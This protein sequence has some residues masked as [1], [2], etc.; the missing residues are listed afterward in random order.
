MQK[1]TISFE[2]NSKINTGNDKRFD[3]KMFRLS[4][5]N[6]STAIILFTLQKIL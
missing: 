3:A 4:T 5:V 2:I 1:C 6:I